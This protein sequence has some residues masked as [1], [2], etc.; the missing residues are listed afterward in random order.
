MCSGENGC[1]EVAFMRNETVWVRDSKN[2]GARP[3]VFFGNEWREFVAAVKNG[4]YD[5]EQAS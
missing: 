4:E 1:V 3:M 2:E 5:G